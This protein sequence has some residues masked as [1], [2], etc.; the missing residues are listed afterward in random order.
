MG[1]EIGGPCFFSLLLTPSVRGGGGGGGWA[2]GG[3]VQSLNF[4]IFSKNYYLSIVAH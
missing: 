1:D 4:S 2:G 3:G